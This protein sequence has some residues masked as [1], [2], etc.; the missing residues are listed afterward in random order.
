VGTDTGHPSILVEPGSG[1]SSSSIKNG[2][3]PSSSSSGAVYYGTSGGS[4]GRQ[5]AGEPSEPNYGPL[6]KNE[7]S[8]AT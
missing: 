6:G 7:H 3:V 8:V 1:Y 5:S 4:S 2:D